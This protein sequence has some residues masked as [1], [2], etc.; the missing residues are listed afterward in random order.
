[1]LIKV[2]PGRYVDPAEAELQAAGAE[3]DRLRKQYEELRVGVERVAQNLLRRMRT[4]IDDWKRSGNP[5][6]DGQADAFGEAEQLVIR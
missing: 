2:G 1:M 5:Y 3:A 6:Y 4:A